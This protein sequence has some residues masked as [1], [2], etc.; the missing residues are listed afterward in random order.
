MIEKKKALKEEAKMKQKL[1][2]IGQN[3][4]AGGNKVKMEAL[5]AMGGKAAK[6]TVKTSSGK[7]VF[8]KFDFKEDAG[9]AEKKQD[10]DPKAA[11]KQIEKKKEKIKVLEDRGKT[12]K[13]KVLED[14]AAWQ[15][16]MDRAEGTVIKDDVTLLKKIHQKERTEKE[17]Q[18]KQVGEQGGADGQEEGR[19]AEQ[20][21]RKHTEEEEGEE[22]KEDGKTW[23]IKCRI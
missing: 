8:S 22:G 23:M 16:A 5:E 19:Q 20:T 21:I 10:I 3:A 7:V 14:R 18:Q 17:V 1:M 11:L 2:K 9:V 6:P 13:I 12:E 15:T 4:G